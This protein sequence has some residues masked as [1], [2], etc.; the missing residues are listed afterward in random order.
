[1]ASKS[2]SHFDELY[3]GE[4]KPQVQ[5]YTLLVDPAEQVAEFMRCRNDPS[6]FLDNYG[7]VKDQD[8]GLLPFKLYDFQFEVMDDLVKY[9]YSIFLK[10]RQMGISTITAG[11]AAWLI[12]FWPEKT[13][14]IISMA[15]EEAQ[16]YLDKVKLIY[17]NLP[18][19][20]KPYPIKWNEKKI[21]LDNG[22]V[23]SATT[24]TTKSGRSGSFSLLIID[25][26]AF[27]QKIDSTWGAAQPTLSKGGRCMIIS[28]P[29][30]LGNWYHQQWES[31]RQ[32][33]SGIK[34]IEL[35]WSR[36]PD[37]NDAWYE[38]MCAKM[39]NARKVAQE[40][41]LSFLGSGD[42]VVSTDVLKAYAGRLE[43]P[44]RTENGGMLWIWE[45]PDPEET[46]IL[47]ADVS[48]G[49]TGD[50]CTFEVL[51]EKDFRQVAEFHG[52]VL[53]V[54]LANIINDLGIRYNYCEVAVEV[55]GGY[56]F[57]V[58]NRLYN[59]HGYE[60]LYFRGHEIGWETTGKT[61]NLIT[62]AV[63]TMVGSGR[64]P[65][66]SSRLY[67]EYTTFVWKTNKRAEHQE[68]CYDDLVFAHGIA[69]AVSTSRDIQY[70]NQRTKAILS[71]EESSEEYMERNLKLF[72][73][74]NDSPIVDNEGLA[75]P[76]WL[77]PTGRGA[78]DV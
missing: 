24:T 57:E 75:V 18:H 72:D 12:I 55:S 35:H 46:Y 26:A 14:K 59:D 58:N 15:L 38:K 65:I 7:V 17:E 36:H 20:L 30:G 49:G 71:G 44:V 78:N 23:C 11:F 22:S 9:Q 40:L 34:P 21:T 29:N 74:A 48:K 1:M 4:E 69:M 25:E 32:G 33:R 50:Y 47:A 37:Y 28:T 8:L 61:R 63:E 60:M 31:A 19:Y 13:V 39:G 53:P 3:F 76:G 16:D 51:S 68:G 73:T 56:G 77:I 45:E 42:T 27:I 5:S 70:G 64:V 41:D 10:S 43:V 52:R 67:G 6:Y 66:R 62:S 2:G 54:R